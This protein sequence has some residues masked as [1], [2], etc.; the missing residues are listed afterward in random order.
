MKEK[1]IIFIVLFCLILLTGCSK[2]STE[3]EDEYTSYYITLTNNSSYDITELVISMVGSEDTQQISLLP[4]GETTQNFEFQLPPPSDD[5]PISFGDYNFSYLQNNEQKYFGI[6]LPET[7]ISVYINN[8]G[9]TVQNMTRL[10]TIM[11]MS[12][13]HVYNIE[14][15]MEG[16]LESYQIDELNINESSPE[17][18][19]HLIYSSPVSCNFGCYIGSYLQNDIT[20][21]I[22][23]YPSGCN[24]ILME[25]FDDG[26]GHFI[27][28]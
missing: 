16:A 9:Y 21:S 20:K 3:V 8:D 5:N 4:M 26:Y 27:E 24:N 17:L 25:I 23:F 13:H 15:A 28:E 7:H 2:S 18:E 6:T 1:L 10:I 11:N 12:S 22:L 14:I 19:F